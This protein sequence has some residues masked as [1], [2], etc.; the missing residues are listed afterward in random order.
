VITWLFVLV[1]A[2]SA[3]AAQDATRLFNKA[4]ALYREGDYAGAVE[5][6]RQC[7]A[8]GVLNASLFYNL[9]NAAYKSNQLGLAIVAFERSLRLR[10]GD[11]DARANLA[12]ANARIVD[13]FDPEMENVLTRAAGVVYGALGA[14]S[15]AVAASLCLFGL[16]LVGGLWLLQPE[17]KAVC[18]AG[19]LLFLVMGGGSLGLFA[20]KMEEHH[21]EEAVIVSQAIDGRSGP[22]NEFL[23]VFTLH[24]GTKVTID[25]FESGWFQI[26]LVNGIAG[27]LP[28]DAVM[29]I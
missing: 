13:R 21:R 27:W 3:T 6:Y 23:K 15:L 10:P 17:R 12:L 8:T 2:S 26:R 7:E 24:E 22:G 4:N 11:V 16:S 29:R 14:G 25:R 20:M 28:R 18:L 9:G 5:K 1:A 19:G